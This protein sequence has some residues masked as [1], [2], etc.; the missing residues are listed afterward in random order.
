MDPN[1]SA[2]SS[3]RSTWSR[4][5]C[6]SSSRCSVGPGSSSPHATAPA[7]RT[8]WPVQT[9]P[10]SCGRHDAS[11]PRCSP[12]GWS[13]S[14]H[15]VDVESGEP[16]VQRRKLGRGWPALRGLL[17]QRADLVHRPPTRPDLLAGVIVAVVALPLALG[18]GIALRA[19]RGRRAHHRDRR[20]RPRG[21]LRRLGLPGLRPHRGDDG[22]PR[23]DRRHSTAQAESSPSASSPASSCSR[24]RWPGPGASS[25]TSPSPW[26]RD[27]P[28][29]IAARDLPPAGAD[30]ARRPA[31]HARSGHCAAAWQAFVDVRPRTPTGRRSAARHRGRGD[32]AD[33]RAAGDPPCRS[34]SSRSIGATVLRPV[35]SNSPWPRDRGAARRRC[36][37]PHWTSCDLSAV[38]PWPPPPSRWPRSPRS[39]PCCPPR[40]PTAWRRPTARSRPRTLRPGHRQP[41][42]PALRR[43]PRDRRDRPHRRQRALRRAFPAGRAHARARTRA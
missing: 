10:T 12:G 4:P 7:S 21:H 25:A 8:R 5:A 18:F 9:S 6:P 43:R 37:H 3:T 29:G 1:R 11:S 13:C 40:S 32:H 14:T 23:A 16:D 39:K 24:S 35:C 20:R 2:N 28:L 30:R 26:S 19:W 33:R 17:P 38:P 42:H 34:P 31:A 22:D 27:S 36:P 15:C 41:R